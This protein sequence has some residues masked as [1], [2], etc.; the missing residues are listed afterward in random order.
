MNEASLC[1]FG[2]QVSSKSAMAPPA[3]SNSQAVSKKVVRMDCQANVLNV[4]N[5]LQPT[6]VLANLMTVSLI[7]S[8][9]RDEIKA[10]RIYHCLP[11]DIKKN[12][13]FK[14]K[15]ADQE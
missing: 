14:V 1:D 5:V 3:I 13:E 4:K 15:A 11:A 12:G 6:G 9:G 8:S 7:I 2:T 10:E